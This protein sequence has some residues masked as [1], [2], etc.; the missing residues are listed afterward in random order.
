MRD[1]GV[2][3]KDPSNTDTHHGKLLSSD[4]TP[5]AVLRTP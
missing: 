3:A 5:G 2:T 4:H 1:V